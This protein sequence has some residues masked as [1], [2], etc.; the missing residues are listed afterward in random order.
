MRTRWWLSGEERA[1]RNHLPKALAGLLA[2]GAVLLGMASPAAAADDELKISHVQPAG[3]D[4]QILLSVPEGT[5]VALDDIAVTIGGEAAEASAEPAGESSEAIRRTTVLAFDTSN[6]M[7]NQGRFEPAKAAALSFL[8]AVPDDVFVGIVSFDS[9]VATEL[10][11]TTDRDAARN[12]VEGLTTARQTLLN[13]GV[14]EAITVAG[15]DGLRQVL[16]LSDGRDTSDTAESDVVAAIT[17]AGVQV[18]VVALDQAA[19]NLGPLES[20]A[21]AG[22]G[23]VIPAETSALTAAFDDEA[24]SLSRQILVNATIPSGVS[25]AEANVAVTA[26]DL[27]TNRRVLIRD[28]SPAP[29]LESSADEKSSSIQISEPVMYLGVAA[30]GL[31]LLVLLGGFMY[32]ATEPKAQPSAEQRIAAYAGGPRPGEASG[33]GGAGLSIDQAK[34]AAASMLKRNKGLEERISARLVAA[35]SEMKAAE[36]ILIHGGIT[37]LAGLVGVLLGSGDIFTLLLFLVLGALVPWL[38]LGWK[39]KKRLDAFQGSLADTLQLVAGSLSAGMS[40]AQSLDTVVKEGNEPIAG[41]F[42]RVLIDARL[43]VPIEDAL[44][45]V[46]TRNESK[47]FAWVVMAIRIQRQVGGNL[48][49]LLNTVAAT[50]REREYLR[51]QVRSLSAE[52]RISGWILGLLPIGMGL[53]MLLIRREYIRPL[54]TETLGIL[55]LAVAATMLVTGAFVMSRIV[56]VEV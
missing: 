54:Y 40:L 55:M 52:G 43:G 32:T 38:W 24:A 14:L 6:S 31:G 17:D 15:T 1:G 49:E 27:S 34:G 53:Y 21:A 4:V 56:K 29:V 45:D 37:V 36:W 13:D 7:V 12:V 35:G 26:G 46:A 9:D 50:L 28:G 18:D 19:G 2:T 48:A 42:K 25:G 47:D 20:F 3:D 11:P 10:T 41:E 51:R 23:S 22:N 33:A 30:L 44:E 8:D 16:V 5:E 39:R